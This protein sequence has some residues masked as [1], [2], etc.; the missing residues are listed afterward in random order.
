MDEKSL[1]F[2]VGVK[3]GKLYTLEKSSIFNLATITSEL[4]KLSS[5]FQNRFR[6]A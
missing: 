2:T 1:R 6:F 3:A 4:S 5:E